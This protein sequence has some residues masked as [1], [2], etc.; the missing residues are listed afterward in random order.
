MTLADPNR[1]WMILVRELVGVYRDFIGVHHPV[2]AIKH[3]RGLDDHFD[4]MLVAMVSRGNPRISV[5]IEDV[6]SHASL[7]LATI[8][9]IFVDLT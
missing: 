6:H 7:T 9:S 1:A 4:H 5:Q 2:R 8:N 3:L